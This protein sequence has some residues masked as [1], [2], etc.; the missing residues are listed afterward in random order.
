[1]SAIQI[2]TTTG[3]PDDARKIAERLIELRLA[4]CVHIDGPIVSW[5][6]WQGA[7]QHD[8]EWRCTIK[9]RR[10]LYAQI[11]QV[12]LDMHPYEQPEILA[13]EV[14]DGSP[15]YLNWLADET[16]AD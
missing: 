15:G 4:A 12:L 13:L 5:F 11:E 14:V 10:E 16:T 9:T 7:V 6:R 8:N 2:V 3:N 1:M